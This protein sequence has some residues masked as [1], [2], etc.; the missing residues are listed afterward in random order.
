MA[1]AGTA[2]ATPKTRQ[3]LRDV[4]CASQGTENM[5]QGTRQK[6]L[7]RSEGTSSADSLPPQKC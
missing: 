7:L 6:S 1:S 3:T 5:A 4:P 2:S